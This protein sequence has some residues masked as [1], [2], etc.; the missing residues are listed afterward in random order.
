[1]DKS[2]VAKAV[3]DQ[4]SQSG[5]SMNKVCE[6][7][8]LVRSSLNRHLLDGHNLLVSEVCQIADALG[9]EPVQFFTPDLA[10]ADRIVIEDG[11]R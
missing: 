9:I 3:R 2:L 4:I 1:M 7:A 6:D 10:D 8:H 11:A 5:K